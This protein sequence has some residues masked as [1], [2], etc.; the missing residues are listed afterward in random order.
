[1]AN[2]T[3]CWP[4][5]VSTST[6]SLPPP[7][8]WPAGRR[9]S[10]SEF[11]TNFPAKKAEISR[12][13]FGSRMIQMLSSPRPLVA[14]LVCFCL[15]L[16]CPL[17]AAEQYK[18]A[19]AV[20]AGGNRQRSKSI[21]RFRAK[22]NLPST[23]AQSLAHPIAAQ[24]VLKYRERL[25]P[26]A[27]RDAEAL[28]SLRQYD[29][30]RRE[31]PRGRSVHDPQLADDRRLLLRRAAGRGSCFTA[32]KAPSPPWSLELLRAPGDS[33]ACSACFRRR[34]VAVGEKWS[35]AAGSARC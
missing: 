18:L 9:S 2:A 16:P 27:G 10:T 26:G 21:S 30:D 28:R 31:N 35:P 14:A 4:I 6:A 7:G 1:M 3:S 23:K 32:R 33:L 13:G 12:A 24:A 15:A 29:V 11:F 34:P 8:L 5:W 22:P 19:G 17:R 25:L 20:A